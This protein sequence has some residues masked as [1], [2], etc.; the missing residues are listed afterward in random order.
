MQFGCQMR[1]SCPDSAC[2]FS[3]PEDDW[4]TFPSVSDLSPGSRWPLARPSLGHFASGVHVPRN[5]RRQADLALCPCSDTSWGPAHPVTNS[6]T[7]W[8][9]PVRSTGVVSGSPMSL[10][11]ALTLHSFRKHL[12]GAS[13]LLHVFEVIGVTG[14]KTQPFTQT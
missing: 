11:S 8:A 5:V 13:Q 1:S 12:R 4:E 7:L 2:P 10:A 9:L 14:D 6:T 3:I